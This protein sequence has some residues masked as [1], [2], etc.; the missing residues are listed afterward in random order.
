[1]VQ[2]SMNQPMLRSFQTSMQQSGI[3]GWEEARATNGQAAGV[4]TGR[5]MT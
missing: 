1:M 5:S 3:G 2:T 4:S